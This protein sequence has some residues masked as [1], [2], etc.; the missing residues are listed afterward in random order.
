MTMT[1]DDDKIL[2]TLIDIKSQLAE[3]N[4]NQ[5]NLQ[6]ILVNHENRITT[7]ES[8]TTK[9]KTSFKDDIIQLLIKGLVGSIFVI[10]SLAGAGGILAKILGG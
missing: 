3:L 2:E 9:E 1:L 7:I 5:K 6:G 10:G 4:A 8:A